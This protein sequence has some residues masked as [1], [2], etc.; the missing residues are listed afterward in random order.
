MAAR[1]PATI[2]GITS[3]II[4]EGWNRG[5]PGISSQRCA[6]LAPIPARSTASSSSTPAQIGPR[7]P[8]PQPLHASCA[9]ATMAT[10]PSTMNAPWRITR[11]AAARWRCTAPPGRRRS[12]QQDAEQR[13]IDVQPLGERRRRPKS[14][15][16]SGIWRTKSPR[17]HGPPSR[18]AAAAARAV[19]RAGGT[20]PR[21]RRRGW[22]APTARITRC[23]AARA[24]APVAAAA[25]DAGGVRFRGAAPRPACGSSQASM[26]LRAIGAAAMPPCSPF[27]TIT[28]T[29]MRGS[30]TGAKAMNSAWSRWRF[31]SAAE[32]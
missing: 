14:R 11:R 23:G 3:F 15:A 22:R 25:R 21:R 6:P 31:C 12:A 19:P 8:A 13:H 16:D 2:I 29:A 26:T 1:K 28:A 10:K 4:S 18:R 17:A 5:S 24:A 20:R 9:T 32:L 30:S 27:S 7:R